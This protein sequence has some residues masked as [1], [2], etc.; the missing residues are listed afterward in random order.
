M[1]HRPL[2][3]CLFYSF[4]LLATFSGV[5]TFITCIERAKQYTEVNELTAEIL[6]LLIERVENGEHE[7]KWSHTASQEVSIN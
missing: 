7:A 5:G 6:N 1:F 3:G 2:Y 4:W